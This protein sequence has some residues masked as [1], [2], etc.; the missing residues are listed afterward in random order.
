MQIKT[1]AAAM[2]NLIALSAAVPNKDLLI[3]PG[4]ALDHYPDFPHVPETRWNCPRQGMLC[5]KPKLMNETQVIQMVEGACACFCI[6]PYVEYDTTN[7]THWEEAHQIVEWWAEG[8]IELPVG[9]IE[10]I[11]RDPMRH[12]PECDDRLIEHEDYG[13]ITAA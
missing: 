8:E 13:A 6:S 1:L 3:T 12:N 10:S 9:P 4:Q 2:A 11:T 7:L 5:P